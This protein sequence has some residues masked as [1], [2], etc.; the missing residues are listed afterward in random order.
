MTDTGQILLLNELLLTNNFLDKE[1]QVVVP[2]TSTSR[3]GRTI[4]PSRHVRESLN[5]VPIKSQGPTVSPLAMVTHSRGVR[6]KRVCELLKF[7]V[8][9]KM[10]Q[11]S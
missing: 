5:K 1:D 7:T 9:S 4:R 10:L 11:L 3:S 6:N 2:S 8:S